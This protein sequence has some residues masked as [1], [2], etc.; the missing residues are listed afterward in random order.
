MGQKRTDAV[1]KNAVRIVPEAGVTSNASLFGKVF[2]A[3][4]AAPGIFARSITGP[5][6]EDV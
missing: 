6:L 3:F 4:C 2:L 5:T 1:S